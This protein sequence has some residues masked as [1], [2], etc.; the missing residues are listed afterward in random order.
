MKIA[1]AG[2]VAVAAFTLATPAVAQRNLD[3]EPQNFPIDFALAQPEFASM[4]EGVRFY[5]ASQP[6]P[7]IVERFQQ[8]AT[9]SQRS[10]VGGR[11]ST[12]ES[13]SRAF[14]NALISLR[15]HALLQGGNAVVNIR[16]NWQHVEFSSET[17]FQC[18]R[19]NMMAGVALKGDI[20]RI[21]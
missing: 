4:T 3:R 2:L 8:N 13:C 21:E 5:F 17:E 19:G 18:V 9:T 1:A 14:L 15:N 6:H 7:D 12:Q 10:S 20:V 16:S 11:K